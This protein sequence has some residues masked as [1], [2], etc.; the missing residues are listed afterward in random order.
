[1]VG[2]VVDGIRLSCLDSIAHLQLVLLDEGIEMDLRSHV[3]H[4]SHGFL[5][6]LL[7]FF[8]DGCIIDDWGIPQFPQ[9]AVEGA[10]R[11]LS[12]KAI[13][14]HGY[15]HQAEPFG[16]RILTDVTIEGRGLHFFGVRHDVYLVQQVLVLGDEL[17]DRARS[18]KA[19]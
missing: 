4:V 18:K 1:V 10:G 17:V 12:R 2:N 3:S 16:I 15:L 6:L 9:E 19:R 8:G 13:D 14:V 5:Y 11:I 7:G